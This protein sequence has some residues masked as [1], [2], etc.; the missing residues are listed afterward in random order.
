MAA[1]DLC[2]VHRILLPYTTQNKTKP[3]PKNQ[4]EMFLKLPQSFLI[5]VPQQS[6]ILIVFCLNTLGCL[7]EGLTNHFCKTVRQYF[8]LRGLLSLL[9][10]SSTPP[11]SRESSHRG[12]VS[13]WAW[14]W[15]NK[16]LFTK[17]GIGP[18]LPVDQSAH[19]R[20]K[21]WS[22]PQPTLGDL[23]PHHKSAGQFVG[24]FLLWPQDRKR[25]LVW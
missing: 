1:D 12:R 22:R 6:V 9:G 3:Q 10:N 2:S 11:L 17:T 25:E 15:S 20:S 16:S 21:T 18:D 14:L 24:E 8:R 7:Q 5:L 19:P 13:A 4:K 23:N